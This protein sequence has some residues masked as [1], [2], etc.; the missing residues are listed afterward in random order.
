MSTESSSEPLALIAGSSQMP[1]VVAEEAR[2]QGRHVIGIG[3]EGVTET[4]LNDV[5]DEVRWL[6]WADVNGFLSLLNKLTKDGVRQAVMVGKVE[7][8][9]IYEQDNSAEL[10]GLLSAVSIRHTDSLLQLVTNLIEGAG[11]E[12]LN[13]TDFLQPYIARQGT[14]TTRGVDDREHEDVNHGWGI[15]K[16]LGALDIGQSVVVK[17]LAVVAVEAMEGTDECLRRGG[18]LAGVGTVL[19]KVAKPDQDLRFDVP[20]V[21]AETIATMVEVGATA[22]CIEADMTVLFDADEFRA[23]AN[24][25]DIAVVAR[26]RD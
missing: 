22:L 26:Q 23:G 18:A 20:V 10:K 11:I 21:G 24:A 16:Q 8:Q 13:C 6:P 25:A 12:L 7:Q 5:A 4:R 15:A 14:L 1:C 3:I 2:A 9:R 17:D 19:V